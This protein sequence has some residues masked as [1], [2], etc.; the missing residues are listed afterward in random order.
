MQ[1]P[2]DFVRIASYLENKSPQECAEFYY[3]TKH[4]AGYKAKLKKQSVAVRKRAT[5]NGWLLARQAASSIGYVRLTRF[6]GC[7]CE[8]I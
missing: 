8:L 7:L 3:L 6:G 1:F 5:R 2:K 4:V